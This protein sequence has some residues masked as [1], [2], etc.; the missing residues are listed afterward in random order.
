MLL[1]EGAPAVPRAGLS[2]GQNQRAFQHRVHDKFAFRGRQAR[3]R[4]RKRRAILPSICPAVR[5]FGPTRS[6][7]SIIPFRE[8]RTKSHTIP[9]IPCVPLPSLLHY[10][11]SFGSCAIILNQSPRNPNYPGGCRWRN[12]WQ[13]KSSALRI[14][15]KALPPFPNATFLCKTSRITL[16]I[17]R[18][19]RR[20][21]RNSVFSQREITR[22][23]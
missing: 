12:T 18:C 5:S 9:T 16:F 3:P 20:A 19:S 23:I 14:G 11:L 10:L 17:T 13:R 1:S 21:S 6:C 7:F 4:L 2:C 15:S 22:A 8:I